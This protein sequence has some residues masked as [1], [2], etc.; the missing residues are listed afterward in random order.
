MAVHV[1]SL[2]GHL[3]EVFHSKG[4]LRTWWNEQR[5]WVIISVTS[6]LFA[7]LNVIMKLTGIKAVNFDLTNK[8]VREKQIQRYE[9]GIFDFEGTSPLLI[10]LTTLSILNVATLIGGGCRVIVQK[11]LQDLFGQLYISCFI[12]VI[13]YPVLEGMIIRR[14]GGRVPASITLWSIILTVILCFCMGDIF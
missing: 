1:S 5:F 2:S 4:S 12:L 9:N 14:D 8:T 7:C 6:Y 13:S 10:P 3:R 11:S